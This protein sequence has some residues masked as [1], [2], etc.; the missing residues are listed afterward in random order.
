MK[1][2]ELNAQEL[3]EING[4]SFLGGSDGSSNSGLGLGLGIGNLLSFSSASKDGDRE[5]A[6]SFSIGNNISTSLQ[7]LSNSIFN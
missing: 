6:S 5:S 1:T 3:R 7:Q 4:G 2:Q